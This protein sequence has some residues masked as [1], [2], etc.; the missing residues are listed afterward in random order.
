MWFDWYTVWGLTEV[1][2]S[3]VSR[4]SSLGAPYS[5]KPF[6]YNIEMGDTISEADTYLLRLAQSRKNYLSTWLYTP[7][8]YN[9]SAE[10]FKPN[11]ST[12]LHNKNLNYSQLRALLD[13]THNFQT[14]ITFFTN[15]TSAFKPTFSS[16][17]T[18]AKSFWRPYSS[19]QSYYYTVTTLMDFLTKREFMYRTY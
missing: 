9:R 16:I 14:T 18:Y 15:P 13:V 17:N 8:L 11:I 3:S 12:L 1:Q 7:Y 10:W 5:R 4:F 19:T 2:F 6:D